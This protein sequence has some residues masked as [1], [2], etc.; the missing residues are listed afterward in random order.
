MVMGER[1]GG[2]QEGPASLTECQQECKPA[3]AGL[4]IL[5]LKAIHLADPSLRSIESQPSTQ[6]VVKKQTNK[7]PKITNK[8][9]QNKKKIKT[10]QKKLYTWHPSAPHPLGPLGPSVSFN[11]SL[12]L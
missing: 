6:G 7:K 5:S 9:E 1:A 11:A 3:A 8:K 10:N 12:E 2:G 4:R